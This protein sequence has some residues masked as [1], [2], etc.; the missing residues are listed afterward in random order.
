RESYV[1][2]SDVPFAEEFRVSDCD[3][4]HNIGF[5]MIYVNRPPRLA[6]NEGRMPSRGIQLRPLRKGW[7][8]E[9]L[10]GGSSSR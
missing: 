6:N 8:D 10:D 1:N 7:T 4:K 3:E 9:A 2:V 5:P